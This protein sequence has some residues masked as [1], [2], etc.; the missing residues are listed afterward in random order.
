M[1]IA[2]ISAKFGSLSANVWIR[3]G[4]SLTT[5]LDVYRAVV[6]PTLLYAASSWTVYSR[7]ARQLNYF[8]LRCLRNLM[9]VRWQDRVPDTEILQKFRMESIHDLLTRSQ[10]HWTGHIFRMP[11]KRLPKS[12]FYGELCEGKRS[13]GWQKKR[14][15]EIT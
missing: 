1:R 4:L 3:C 6:L 14:F 2:R 11:D 10:L 9:G 8:H 5:K 7:H 12:L 15:K 13:S